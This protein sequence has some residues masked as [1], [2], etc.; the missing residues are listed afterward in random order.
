[1]RVRSV[2]LATV[3]WASVVAAASGLAW[4]VID[5]A[6]QDLLATGPAVESAASARPTQSATTLQASPGTAPSPS[7]ATPGAS[8]SP[9]GPE[10]ATAPPTVQERTWSGAAGTV[11]VRC[12]NGAATF[13]AFPNDGWGVEKAERE[14]SSDVE[15]KFES[16]ERQTE[17]HARCVGGVPQFEVEED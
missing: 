14:E 8:Q 16:G 9:A 10:T 4:A 5:A 6:G 1:M 13:R 11:Q 15:V 17:V 12:D 3:V 7:A 2:A